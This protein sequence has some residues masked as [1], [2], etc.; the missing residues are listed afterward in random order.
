[1]N[2]ERPEKLLRAREE[3]RQ[4]LA[5]EDELLDEDMAQQMTA[6]PAAERRVSSAAERAK[7][8]RAR[9]QERRVAGRIDAF[10]S[11]KGARIANGLYCVLC[12][13]ICL[14]MIT[15]LL[16]TVAHMPAFGAPDAPI[17]N[18]VSARYIERGLQETG[19]VNIVT[20]MILDYRAFDTLGESTVLFAA[21]MVVMMLLRV[22]REFDASDK[23]VRALG[24]DPRSDTYYE[25]K[26]DAILQR[27][28]MI[29]VPV[30]L[31]LGI[32]VV[33]NGHLS[34]GGGFSGGAIAGAGLMLYAS[35]FGFE[36]IRKFFTYRT[37]QTVVLLALL[38]YALS[39]CYSF[40]TGANGI[41]SA[42]P[43]GTPGALLS[44]GLIF[45]LN[46]CVG[47]IVA[48]TMYAFF[49]VFRKGELG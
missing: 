3:L 40:Y 33:L 6:Q 16:Y 25:P 36:R 10:A 8:A 47:F 24:E 38:T 42:I 20:G 49:A 32:Y 46:V 13:G 30:V 1:M 21:A 22:D 18:E 43:L 45:V 15:L 48:C 28:A 37:Y 7:A 5:D 41:P 29:L 11:G 31:L 2:R 14:T 4:W 19:A 35:A 27:T 39:K 17:N 12:T 44:S 34:P 26:H 9:A 23:M